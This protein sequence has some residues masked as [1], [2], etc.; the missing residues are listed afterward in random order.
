MVEIDELR[1]CKILGDLDDRELAEVAKVA[2]VEKRG[3]GSRVI[4]EGTEAAALYLLREGKVE[5]RM[6][7]RDG[8]EVVIDELGPGEL[9]GWSAVLDHKTFRAAIWTVEDSTLIV[10]DGEQL[11]RLFEANNHIGYRVVRMIADIVARRME[12]MRARLV[13]QPFSEQWL[14]PVRVPSLPATGEKSEMRSMPCP[15]CSTPNHPLSVVNETEQYRCGSCGMVYY[16]PVGCETGPATPGLG[17]ASGP[18]VQL[19]DNWSAS[20]PSGS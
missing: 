5:V 6:T 7:S 20:T 18:E 16:T 19:P 1:C 15:E 3:A 10:M 12:R 4:T 2:T 9:F 17:A 13:D 14:A 11:R 8:H